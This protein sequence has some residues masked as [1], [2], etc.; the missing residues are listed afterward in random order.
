MYHIM[1]TRFS[2]GSELL[3]MRGETDLNIPI[4]LH[5]SLNILFPLIS[6]NIPVSLAL[7]L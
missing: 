2:A 1:T 7:Y 3:I 6:L 4:S 5:I